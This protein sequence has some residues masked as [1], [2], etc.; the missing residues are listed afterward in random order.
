MCDLEQLTLHLY[1]D[2][3]TRFVD[4]TQLHNDILIHMP[5]LD[6]FIF[7]IRTIT[8]IVD[9]VLGLSNEDI[10]RTFTKAGY[11]QVECILRNS[12]TVHTMCH[13][14]SLPFAFHRL[15]MVCNNFPNIIFKNVTFLWVQDAVPFKHE[16]FIRI[17]QCFPLLKSLSVVNFGPQISDL[18]VCESDNDQSHSVNNLYSPV[19]YPYIMTLDIMYAHIDYVEQLLHKSKTHLPRL[20]ELKIK[21]DRLQKVTKNFTRDATRLNCRLVKWLVVNVTAVN[22][23]DF[24]IYFPLL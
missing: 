15:E 4:G 5:R 8:Q 11:E 3:R 10:R 22:P 14:F 1:I 12:S 7:C 17:A 23:K 2:D 24:Y 13:V 20:T 16:F 19:E 9:S 21:Y 18:D 6:T